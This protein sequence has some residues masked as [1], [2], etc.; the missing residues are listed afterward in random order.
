MVLFVS[1]SAT[2]FH[3]TEDKAAGPGIS[4]GLQKNPDGTKSEH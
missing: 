2:G 1:F 3:P 4:Q